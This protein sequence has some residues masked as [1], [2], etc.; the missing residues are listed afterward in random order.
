MSPGELDQFDGKTL[1]SLFGRAT[2][3]LAPEQD[4]KRVSCGSAREIRKTRRI[5]PSAFHRLSS[6]ARISKQSGYVLPEAYF[7]ACV[8]LGQ[9]QVTVKVKG[10]EDEVEGREG[11]F[12]IAI[13][14]ERD[15][16]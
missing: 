6:P 13:K 15:A 9:R 8:R 7:V 3:A 10:M 5:C 4:W 11:E 2:R 1:S 14:K 16:T 12:V